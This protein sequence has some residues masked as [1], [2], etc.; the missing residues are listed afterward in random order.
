MYQI[1]LTDPRSNEEKFESEILEKKYDNVYNTQSDSNYDFEPSILLECPTATE[2]I[3]QDSHSFLINPY[4]GGKLD[5]LTKL[6]EMCD[7]LLS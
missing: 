7:K 6:Q 5:S 4:Q 3:L 1:T 2:S